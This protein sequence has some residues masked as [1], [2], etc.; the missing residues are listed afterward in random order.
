MHSS[1]ELNMR[2]SKHV[3]LFDGLRGVAILLVIA[4]HAFPML[5]ELPWAV[6]RFSNLGFYGVQLFFVTSCITLANSWRRSEAYGRPSLRGFALRRIFRIVPAYFLAA[7]GYTWLKPP[8]S[9]DATQLVTFLTFSN[10]WTPSLMPTVPNTWIG[11]P[12]GWSIEAE[13]GFYALFPIVATVLVG[14]T[15]AVAGLLLSLV[16]AWMMNAAGLA[17]YEPVYGPAATDQFLYYWLPNQLPVFLTG[18]VAYEFLAECPPGRRLHAAGRRVVAAAPVLLALCALAFLALAIVTWPRLPQV[19]H[20]FLP[21]HVISAFTFAGAAI[22]LSLRPLPVPHLLIHIGQASFS[23][24]LIHFAVIAGFQHALPPSIL[25]QT[26]VAA[27]LTSGVLFILVAATT[28]AVA[29]LTYRLIELPAIRLGAMAVPASMVSRS[30]Q[31]D[32]PNMM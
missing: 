10:G 11:V 15:R 23:A 12:G 8:L 27:V 1:P 16:L 32:A 9:L 22:A 18:L 20:G 17:A 5:P 2:T 6:K 7:V 28:V 19:G 24:Y 13:F 3:P 14:V 30:A 26:G 31:Y 4:S 25:S 21:S 29:Q